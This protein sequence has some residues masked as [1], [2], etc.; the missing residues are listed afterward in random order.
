MPK[1]ARFGTRSAVVALLAVTSLAA[2]GTSEPS[3]PA[4]APVSAPPSIDASAG[5]PGS[6]SPEMT[7]GPTTPSEEPT[8][9]ELSSEPPTASVSPT[10]SPPP[11]PTEPVTSE[12]G[13]ADACTV[14][15]DAN[16][17]FFV[18][19]A[20][21]V[22]WPVL[23][24]VLPARWLLANGTYHLAHG[25]DMTVDYNGPA[26]ASLNLQEG[27]F[28]SD[29]GGCVPAGSDAGDA[30]LGPLGGTLVALNDGGFAIVVDRG[31]SPSWLMTLH[32]VDQA[33]ATSIG[34]A[35]VQVGG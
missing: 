3:S 24:A 20:D 25:G 16:R 28:C 7:E 10:D 2:C 4:L 12:P 13:A 6:A 31:A 14:S 19:V 32:G 18:R 21:A 5:P 26:G 15:N 23:C 1:P 35:M 29:S 8:P 22:E 33:T 11:E 17:E 9:S 34:A 30:A 27:A